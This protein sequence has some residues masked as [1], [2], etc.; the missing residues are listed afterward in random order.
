MSSATLS[1]N[2]IRSSPRT[3]G[4]GRNTTGATARTYVNRRD[5]PLRFSLP[6]PGHIT[7]ETVVSDGRIRAPTRNRD[8]DP[9]RSTAS[10][11]PNPTA[12]PPPLLPPHPGNRNRCS[13][14]RPNPDSRSRTT[15][16]GRPIYDNES[17]RPNPHRRLPAASAPVG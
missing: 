12:G 9:I 6:P 16:S 1:T 3:D 10:E 4:R 2:V 5:F 11:R 15:V 13:F 7:R 14:H 8:P 17:R